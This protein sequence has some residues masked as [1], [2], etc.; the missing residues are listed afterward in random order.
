MTG[1][2]EKRLAAL[3]AKMRETGADLVALGAGSHMQW[4]VGFHPMADE[5]LC[6]MLV[7]PEHETIVMP[8]LNAGEMRAHT[9][10]G[11][12][13]WRD[14]DGPDAAL[15][16]AV[17]AVA[18]GGA[19]RV[20]ID[21]AM[22][23]DF[24]L[25]LLGKLDGA[26]PVFTGDTVGALRL[27]KGADEYEI[28]K[29]NAVIDDGAFKKAAAAARPGMTESELAAIINDHF[30]SEGA[31]PAFAIVAAGPNGAFPH[32]HTGAR[33]LETGDAVVVDIGGRKQ[34]YPSDMTR[35]L[36]IGEKPEGYDEVH[37][38]VERA[39]Q[40]A[41]AAAKPGARAKDVDKAARDTIAAAGY[42]E[43]FTHRTGHGMGIDG[44]EP[45]FITA[46]NDQILEE[47]MVFSI[48][49]GIYLP[50][51]FGVRLED[52]VII[53]KDGPEILSDLPRTLAIAKE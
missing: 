29:M 8:A 26:K 12:V 37:E 16:E 2:S 23:A 6:L 45:P 41:L 36:A 19:Q 33:K 27:I 39:V 21:E 52:I 50:G 11:F 5:R 48:E 7:G 38:T 4:L 1:I 31:A 34:G 15:A 30:L 44:H 24:A 3:R 53:R 9:D 22:R 10:I 49:P 32:H 35:M 40:A 46:T 47:G 14:D 25:A 18:P 28:L 20:V 43:F 51:R 42:G 17:A 13:E